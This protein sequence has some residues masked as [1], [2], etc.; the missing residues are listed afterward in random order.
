MAPL[1]LTNDPSTSEK[2]SFEV[3]IKIVKVNPGEETQCQ[4]VP[5]PF[6][7][8]GPTTEKVQ[9]CLLVRWKGS[10]T[11]PRSVDT[12][13]L[14]LQNSLFIHVEFW[15]GCKLSLSFSLESPYRNIC[16][17]SSL[18]GLRLEFHQFHVMRKTNTIAWHWPITMT[19]WSGPIFDSSNFKCLSCGL[20][21][22]LLSIST[23]QLVTISYSHTFWCFWSAWSFGRCIFW[24][25]ICATASVHDVYLLNPA[26]L[27]LFLVVIHVP[28]MIAKLISIK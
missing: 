2:G 6:Q 9:F 8:E 27:I 12:L 17:N 7:G 5:F 11:M 13:P 3:T 19:I 25:E 10:M 22:Y 1:L 4:R 28:Y 21:S 23:E 15:C 26:L 20:I 16:S 14:H 18:S 24:H